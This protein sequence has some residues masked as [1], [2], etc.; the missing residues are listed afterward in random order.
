MLSDQYK[1]VN[2]GLA[3]L[4][5]ASFFYFQPAKEVEEMEP[6]KQGREE[7]NGYR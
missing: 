7:D 1:V 2:A 4:G 5:I 3:D 6:H